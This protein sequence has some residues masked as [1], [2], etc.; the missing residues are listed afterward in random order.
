MIFNVPLKC[1]KTLILQ[2]H[3]QSFYIYLGLRRPFLITY[4]I[5]RRHVTYLNR[6]GLRRPSIYVV[7]DHRFM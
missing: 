7:S 1:D 6:K 3:V 5:I 4:L 2:F